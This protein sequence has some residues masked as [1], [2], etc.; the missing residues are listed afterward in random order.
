MIVIITPK[1]AATTPMAAPNNP[2]A[3]PKSAAQIAN[4]IGNVITRMMIINTLVDEDWLLA[5]I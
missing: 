1:S 3:T 2:I 5:V 4:Q